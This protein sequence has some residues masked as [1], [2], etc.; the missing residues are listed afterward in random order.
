MS[1]PGKIIRIYALHVKGKKPVLRI[2]DI[3]S[4]QPGSRVDKIQDP[5]FG[6]ATKN[7]IIFAQKTYN[8]I[9]KRRPRMFFPALDF[10]PSQ[11]PELDPGIKKAPNP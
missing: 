5:V 9:S 1:G 3:N 11:I 6:F 2:R 4:F 7:L 10:F 8:K